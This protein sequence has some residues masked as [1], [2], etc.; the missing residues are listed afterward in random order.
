MKHAKTIFYS[1]LIKDPKLYLYFLF[2]A[3]LTY[4]ILKIYYKALI[5]FFDIINNLIKFIE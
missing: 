1:L 2:E 3:R 4:K 5:Y